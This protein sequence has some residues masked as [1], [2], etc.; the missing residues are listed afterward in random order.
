M[1]KHM[2]LT[3]T[4]QMVTR[5]WDYA[6]TRPETFFSFQVGTVVARKFRRYFPG[7]A[8]IV[9]YGA[10]NGFLIEDLLAI[11]MRCG[12]VEF[13]S[14]PVEELNERFGRHPSFLGARAHDA[15]GDWRGKCAGVFL[16]EV[17]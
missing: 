1:A 9:D 12:A 2:E 17:I 15:I 11:G 14:R 8:D 3:W 7:N 16:V 6:R 13:G 4:R 5:F 10:G